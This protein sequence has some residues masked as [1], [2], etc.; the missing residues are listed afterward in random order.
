MIPDNTN[1][2]IFSMN[3][4]PSLRPSWLFEFAAFIKQHFKHNVTNLKCLM[5]KKSR[6]TH[7]LFQQ[8]K[9]AALSVPNAKQIPNQA[10]RERKNLCEWKAYQLLTFHKPGALTQPTT[11]LAICTYC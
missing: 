9:I 11:L 10:R 3:K 5:S 6:A 4:P 1:N 8:I 7:I 2:L